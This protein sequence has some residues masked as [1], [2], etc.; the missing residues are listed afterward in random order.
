MKNIFPIN[1]TQIQRNK[2]NSRGVMFIV[3]G[4]RLGD[5]SLDLGRDG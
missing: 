3:V 4:N 2:R 1:W 5:T